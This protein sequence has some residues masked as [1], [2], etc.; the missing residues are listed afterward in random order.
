METK[1]DNLNKS[2]LLKLKSEIDKQLEVVEQDRLDTIKRKDS[3]KNKIKL[4][5][6]TH[7]DR[8]FGIGLS[9]NNLEVYFMDYCDVRG[10][11]DKTDSDYH[12]ISV[13]HKTISFGISTSIHKERAEKHY[14]L[15][16][17]CSIIYF[18]TLKPETW[19]EDLQESFEYQIKQRKKNFN[20]EI[21]TLRKE[22]NAIINDKNKINFY[23]TK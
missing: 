18:F 21:K 15:F 22:L 23:I 1:I 10:Y 20:R 4:C 19:E 5:E 12:D 13:G 7:N 3:V 8:I 11:N 9:S 2:D 16:I 6:L 17:S 14:V